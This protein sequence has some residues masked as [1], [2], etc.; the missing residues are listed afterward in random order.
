MGLGRSVGAVTGPLSYLAFRF[1]RWNEAD[2]EFFRA[3]GEVE[4]RQRGEKV[5]DVQALVLMTTPEMISGALPCYDFIDNP[6][7]TCPTN[8]SATGAESLPRALK[9]WLRKVW[10]PIAHGRKSVKL[11][12]AE[13]DR[14]DL[15]GTFQRGAQIISA[16]KSSGGLGKELWIN[17]TGG[18]NVINLALQFAAALTGSPARFYY[19]QAENQAAEKCIRY[20]REDSYWVDLPLLPVRV[21]E[22]MRRLVERVVSVGPTAVNSLFTQ[23][24]QEL[25]QHFQ[26]VNSLDQFR[27]LFLQ[28][29]VFQ[30]LL[31]L[32]GDVVRAGSA[33][34]RLEPY[35]RTLD[36]IGTL[37][38]SLKELTVQPWF[39]E[40]DLDLG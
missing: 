18:N 26:E 24:T 39:R 14:T 33:W 7:G 16:A 2:R 11:Y 17:L 20:T 23:T 13:V 8:R 1:G 19:V 37:P 22:P 28:P 31:T 4:Q 29:L 5:G 32:E 38:R 40:E 36:G 30:G 9:R 27:R 6:E 21:D 25:W 3:S 15:L 10:P 34:A 35:Y 12:W